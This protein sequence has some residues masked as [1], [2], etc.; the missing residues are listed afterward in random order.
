M[1]KIFYLM[2]KSAS[3]KDT[4]FKM[5]MQTN[6]MGLKNIVMYTT[7]PIRVGEQE[8]VDYYF[9]EDEKADEL[10]KKGL[11]IE[12][13]KYNTIHGIWKYFTVIDGQVDLNSGNYLMIGTL[14]SYE[15]M[16]A[17]YG[18]DTMV[19]IYVTVPDGIRLERALAREKCQKQPKYA[20]MCR[21]FL[22]D[23]EDFKEEN[24]KKCGICKEK[25]SFENLDINVCINKIWKHIQSLCN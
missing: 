22:A 6:E 21:R 9:V 18:V 3:G 12:M 11:V 13:R 16:R 23:E 15:K 5:L 7:R 14:E 8:G 19:P 17:F 25:D 10:G 20:E 2:G 1:G 4:I 24:L